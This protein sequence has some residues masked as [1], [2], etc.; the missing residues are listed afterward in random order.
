M[1]RK[2]DEL[3]SRV[4]DC[5][6]TAHRRAD[7]TPPA[8]SMFVNLLLEELRKA[9]LAAER[10]PDLETAPNA[11]PG[12][13]VSGS[14]G[15]AEASSRPP[16][17]GAP[18]RTVV[19]VANEILLIARNSAELTDGHLMDA[20]AMLETAKLG[21]AIVVSAG[22][23]LDAQ[24]IVT[25]PF[26]AETI[27]AEIQDSFPDTSCAGFKRVGIRCFDCA[28]G[29]EDNLREVARQH[30]MEVDALVSRL[31]AAFR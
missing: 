16:Q 21:K 27:V 6:E 14:A 1:P 12:V 4:L 24:K 15:P 11:D 8:G 5:V 28:I 9:E 22:E 25:P 26:S 20:R 7:A 31:N 23:K 3:V 29:Y 2:R 30:E 17:A 19:L 10:R 13:G 18:A